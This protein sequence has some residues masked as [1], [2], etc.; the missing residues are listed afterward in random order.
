MSTRELLN[1]IKEC[2]IN[3]EEDEVIEY[4]N[5]ALDMSILPENIIKNGLIKGMDKVSE[6]YEEDEYFLPEVLICSDS[7]NRGLDVVKPHV[8]KDEATIPIKVVMG[9]VEGDTHD[10]GKNLVKI[11]ME[12]GGIEVYDLGRDVPLDTFIEKAEEVK[13]DIIGMS[14]LM[15]TTMDGMRIVIEKLKEKGIRDKYKIM[16]G[17]GPISQHFATSIGAD[18]YTEDASEAARI[19]KAV[20]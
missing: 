12:S 14:T 3:M 6:L 20:N 11:M 10:I 1:K 4:C 7:F 5:K 2:V 9:V 8:I 19:I 18:I 15:T 17:G 13:A 16:I